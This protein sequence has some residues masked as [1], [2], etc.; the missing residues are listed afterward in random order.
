MAKISVNLETMTWEIESH[1]LGIKG[2]LVEERPG[3][4]VPE[5]GGFDNIPGFAPNRAQEM[6]A[7]LVGVALEERRHAERKKRQDPGSGG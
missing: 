1:G 2:A 6:I 5:P 4:I 7:Y 3:H